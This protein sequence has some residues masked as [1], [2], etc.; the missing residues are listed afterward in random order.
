MPFDDTPCVCSMPLFVTVTVSAIAP[1]RRCRPSRSQAAAVIRQTARDREAAIAAT[2][3]DRLREHRVGCG[4]R[5]VDSRYRID[6]HRTAD[7]ADIA[8]AAETERE[9]RATADAARDTETAIPATAADRLRDDAIGMHAGGRDAR[10]GCV[11]GDGDA[12]RITARTALAAESQADTAA[13]IADRAG[14][15]E[16]ARPAATADRLRDDRMRGVA[17]RRDAAGVV[18]RDGIRAAAR[19]AFAAETERGTGTIDTHRAADRETT[20]TAAT[21]DRLRFDTERTETRRCDLARIIER[22]VHG[23]A[24]AASRAA[25][26]EA[27]RESRAAAD[28]DREAAIATAAANRLRFDALRQHAASGDRAIIRHRDAA[29]LAAV[30][31]RTANANRQGCFIANGNADRKTAGAATTTDRL[32]ENATR[33]IAGRGDR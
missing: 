25:D 15:A 18:E 29:T 4:A 24:A 2:A 17:G 27:R 22:D 6:A 20:I 31:A 30:A 28:R 1:L 32:R 3:A 26:R 13:I 33:A 8:R 21:A 14:D 9:P 16:T 7:T 12:H 23:A 10:A 5:C 19:S 11:V